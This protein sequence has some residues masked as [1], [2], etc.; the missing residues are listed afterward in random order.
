[1]LSNHTSDQIPAWDGAGP[2]PIAIVGM[3]GRFPKAKDVREFWSRL[4]NAEDCI[5]RLTPEQLQSEGIDPAVFQDPDYV[6]AAPVLDDIEQFDAEFFGITPREAELMDPQQ[7]IFLECCW[8]ALED[9][10]YDPKSCGQA[11]GLFAG[12][13][14]DTYLL[15]IFSHPDLV[16]AVGAVH[17]G[18]GNDLAFLT[19]R[20]SHFLNLTGPAVSLHTACS[21]SLVAVHIACDTLRQHR[22]DAA[23][24]GG[25]AVNV[26]HYVGYMYEEGSL[27]SPDGRCRTFD[28]SAR[29][30]VFGSGAGVV[31]LKRLG[32]ALA[33]HDSI[34]AVIR[35]SA[36]NN[37]GSDKASFT[38]PSAQGQINVIREA[39]RI[40]DV[41]PDTIGYIECHGTGTPLGDAIEVRALIKAFGKG[42]PGSCAIGSVKTNVGH[43]DVA[44]G[45]T[46]LIKTA[47]SLKHRTIP[48][49]LHYERPNPQISF[50]GTRFYVNTI[51]SPWN[52]ADGLRRA[53][54]SAFGVGGT[55]AHVILEEAPLL[56]PSTD[57]GALQVLPLSARSGEALNRACRAL[58]EHLR[59]HPQ[60]NLSDIAFTLQ[61][62][63]HPFEFRRALVCSRIDDA[64]AALDPG[65]DSYRVSQNSW[66]VIPPAVTLLFPGQWAYPRMGKELYETEPVFRKHIRQCS[67]ILAPLLDRDLVALLYEAS[68]SAESN[69]DIDLS[70][71]WIAQPAL[72]AVEYALARLW[73]SWGVEP[74][75]MFG[76]SLGEYTAA[77]LAEV[78]SIEEALRLVAVRGQ[79]MQQTAPGAMLAVSR[80]G[81]DIVPRLTDELAVVAF[82]APDLC[83]IA[84]TPHA[85][86]ILGAEL[87]AEGIACQPLRTSHAFHT[88]LVEPAMGPF[89]S[90]LRR[91]RLN[92][93]R[94]PFISCVTGTWIQAAEAQSPEYWFRQMR[95]PVQFD[96]GLT[97][98]LRGENRILLDV[99]PGQTLRDL[100]LRK[101]R[102]Y[103][104]RQA[105][106]A[107]PP[108]AGSNEQRSVLTALTE[109]WELGAPLEWSRVRQGHARRVSLP[110]YPFERNR[111]WIDPVKGSPRSMASAGKASP[112]QA[113]EKDPNVSRWFW[114]P[115]PR[116]ASPVL[117][118]RSD[119]GAWIVYGG[120]GGLGEEVCLGLEGSGATVIRIA[121]GSEFCRDGDFAYKMNPLV[122][123]H[124]ERLWDAVLT[125]DLDIANVVCLSGVDELVRADR[126][127][128]GSGEPSGTETITGN[129]FGIQ[130]ML[131]KSAGRPCRYFIVSGSLMGIEQDDR[132]D[133][134]KAG[135][136]ALAKT[137]GDEHENYRCRVIDVVPPENHSQQKETA[138]RIVEE[139]CSAATEEIVAYRGRRRWTR[140]FERIEIVQQ[141]A[142]QN[143]SSDQGAYLILGG[144]GTV[145]LLVA[146]HLA[147]TEQANLLLTS[148][149]AL[150]PRALWSELTESDPDS[151]LAHRIRW[152]L[153]IE[154]AGAEVETIA[155]DIADAKQ[156]SSTLDYL[157]G[158]FGAVR[159]II[160]TSGVTSGTSA[161]SP[162]SKLDPVAFDTQSRTKLR[163][164]E[165]LA[166]VIDG[167][168]VPFVLLMS[169][170][171]SIVGGLGS[172]AYAAANCSMNAFAE[173]LSREQE[174]TRWL[175]ISWDHWPKIRAAGPSSDLSQLYS[176]LTEAEI[177]GALKLN[178]RYAM[179]IEEVHTALSNIFSFPGSG[180]LI[181]ST[182]SLTERLSLAGRNLSDSG[183]P[184]DTGGDLSSPKT[185]RP[186]LKNVYVAPR[187]DLELTLAALWED[188]L[189][190][191]QVGIH[192]DF[193]ELGGHSL[194]ATKLVAQVRS[195]IGVE[196]PLAKLFE[197]PTITQMA[198][199]ILAATAPISK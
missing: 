132:L 26:P 115:S 64:I 125:L 21:T 44:A 157:E 27:Q 123:E 143:L 152:I 94:I 23:L 20:V 167:R 178:Y 54:V 35:G 122:R 86:R 107:M 4:Y 121:T 88:S 6:A 195:K 29:G 184:L 165:V 45:M 181:V 117:E 139:I 77:A 79:L 1:M 31:V 38:T 198:E 14:T 130:A 138:Q 61:E 168:A 83:T 74:K 116:L 102:S 179:T 7:R 185:Q 18:L 66:A 93:P 189:G 192:D 127:V 151:L 89:L 81:A 56:P 161:F 137:L 55:N 174:S 84:G 104:A 15:N 70:E 120:R 16:H 98:L 153:S 58:A 36:V 24:A 91:I 101:S 63:R 114:M 30:M 158:R 65:N 129:L 9:A 41:S 17:L 33:S 103:E 76:H 52:P 43:L 126:G 69:P 72:L 111:F 85:I 87:K 128:T 73:I 37:D 47:L 197:E 42:A 162:W 97:E 180:H 191:D 149:T 32:D 170:N 40:A 177:M 164:L 49:S 135:V 196:L 75:S 3:A 171:S 194:L 187:N 175:S 110:T 133:P 10:G 92:P 146:E 28:A 90:E 144:L 172:T 11:M 71:T 183:Q 147:R 186:N 173:Q 25:V 154:E 148:R 67:D 156:I 119:C 80:S 62:G 50:E 105:L 113:A 150:P 8:E 169:S 140:A 118:N 124:H 160:H 188:F 5:S 142:V 78:M 60:L 2:E 193:F 82:N 109:L 12:A 112:A 68:P 59:K 155:V 57:E 166:S 199:N 141:P 22:C 100:A 190:I 145:G 95:F 108:S 13:R 19:T 159:G 48:A 39:L 34:Y 136:V 134:A 106:A 96:A 99:G 131:R 182:G 176:G 46:G 51:T 53:G 163:G